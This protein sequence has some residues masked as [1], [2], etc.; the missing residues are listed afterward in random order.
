MQNVV[1]S[2]LLLQS[3]TNGCVVFELIAA[4]CITRE[5]G[6]QSL[7]QVLWRSLLRS[8]LI[9]LLKVMH[10]F[11]VSVFGANSNNGARKKSIHH[12]IVVLV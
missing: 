2:L 9:V 7:G 6:S 12:H 11:R 4:V 10:I 3:M 1:D 8:L 5:R